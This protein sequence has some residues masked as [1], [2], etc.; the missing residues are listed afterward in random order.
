MVDSPIGLFLIN[1]QMEIV[2]RCLY[3]KASAQAAEEA[4]KLLKGSPS[5]GVVS[6]LSQIGQATVTV[7][8]KDLESALRKVGVDVRF[9][10]HPLIQSFRGQL[11]TRLIQEG[12]FK[13]EEEWRSFERGFAVEM[14][15]IS[16]AMRVAQRDM[17][18]IQAVRAVDDVDKTLNL[19]SGR[20]REWYGLHF[21]ELD[22]LLDSH[23]RYARF[24]LE[25][26]DRSNLDVDKLRRLGFDEGKANII[27]QKSASSSGG[28]ISS[29]DLTVLQDFCERILELYRLRE[30][31]EKYVE[32]AME[33]V[34]PNLS[35]LIGATISARLISL[36][37]GLENLAKMPASTVQVLGAEKALFR[38]IK[39]GSR[40]PKHGVIFQH[41]AVHQSPRWQRGKIARAL[42]GKLAIAA[43]LDAFS[44][45]YMGEELKKVLE[46][47]IDE[48]KAKYSKPPP[49]K[50]RRAGRARRRR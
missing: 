24:V 2:G 21:P 10:R 1:D 7:D 34:A 35:G 41:S 45:E 9:A 15:R 11:P 17:A 31:L 18:V 46:K 48:V 30:R 13:D 6:F 4:I 49:E 5:H 19:F 37:G 44:G 20:M 47:R 23:E 26:G 25:V 22:K 28:E 38:A 39:T 42:A 16:I 14:A 33:E 8:N 12:V 27:L 43:R 50:R 3:P 32:E 40:P 29:E 36:A